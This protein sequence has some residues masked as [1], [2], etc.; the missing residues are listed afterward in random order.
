MREAKIEQLEK[1]RR[2]PANDGMYKKWKLDF[3]VV[4]ETGTRYKCLHQQTHL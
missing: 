4:R 2:E 3:R 1:P